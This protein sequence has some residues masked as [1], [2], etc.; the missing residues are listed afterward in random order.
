MAGAV[1]YLAGGSALV[2]VMAACAAILDRWLPDGAWEWIFR[3]IGWGEVSNT[4]KVTLD[5]SECQDANCQCTH[6]KNNNNTCCFSKEISC[7]WDPDYNCWYVCPDF[8]PDDGG[9]QP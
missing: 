4:A 3:K 8:E 6:C 2:L 7:P 5:D 1:L 9:K